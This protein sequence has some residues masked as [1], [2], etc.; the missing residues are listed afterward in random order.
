MSHGNLRN[1]DCCVALVYQ[2]NNRQGTTQCIIVTIHPGNSESS[3]DD[4]KGRITV[5]SVD[6]LEENDLDLLIG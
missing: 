4:S 3:I 1:F 6:S 5:P 2:V